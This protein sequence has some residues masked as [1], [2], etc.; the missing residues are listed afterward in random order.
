MRAVVAALGID[1]PYVIFG[2]THRSGPWERDD[3]SEWALPNGGRL[4]NSGSW[5]VEPAFLG[6]VPIESP[7][8]PSVIV[9]VDDEPGTAPRLERLYD[10]VSGF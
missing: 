3:A 2:H 4:T 10:D 6:S 1:A 5:V 9:W 8:F 7:Y